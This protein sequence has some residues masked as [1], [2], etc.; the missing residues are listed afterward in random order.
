MCTISPLW[1]LVFTCNRNFPG[2]H[3]IECRTYFSFITEI[4]SRSNSD[5]VGFPMPLISKH[6]HK[7]VVHAT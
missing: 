1:S 5:Q 4:P 2:I 6:I 3:E 7:T